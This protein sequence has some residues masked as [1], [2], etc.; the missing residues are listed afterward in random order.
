MR[1]PSLYSILKLHSIVLDVST[2]KHGIRDK[3]LLQSIVEKPKANFGGKDL[4]PDLFTKAA[5]YL[6]SIVQYHVFTD[7]NKRT[8][9]AIANRFITT[10]GY[11]FVATKPE[12]VEFMVTVAKD[13]TPIAQIAKWL[14]QHSKKI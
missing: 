14:E 1:Y 13:K 3:H 10:N 7:G 6:E 4:Y 9:F 11:K 8:A 5:I 12:I 2:G